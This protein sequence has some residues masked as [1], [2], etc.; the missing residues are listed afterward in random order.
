MPC[1]ARCFRQWW[2]KPT[3]LYTDNFASVAHNKKT[4]KITP[5]PAQAA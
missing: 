4:A 1:T 2:P 5:I 3:V